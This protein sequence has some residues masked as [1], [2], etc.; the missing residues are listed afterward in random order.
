MRTAPLQPGSKSRTKR[1]RRWGALLRAFETPRLPVRPLLLGRG[2]PLRGQFVHD[3][4]ENFGQF[5]QELVARQPG[6]PLQMVN[7]ISPERLLKLLRL[8][9]L[10]LAGANPRLDLVVMAAALEALHD[11]LK[12]GQ[13]L[14]DPGLD[15]AGLGVWRAGGLRCVALAFGRAADVA[16]GR[17]G[18]EEQQKRLGDR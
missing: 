10:V 13:T 2:P 5:A 7:L 14:Q 12:A 18:C 6:L 1:E 15:R 4:R 16:G 11:G 17:L 9:G 8:D 3:L